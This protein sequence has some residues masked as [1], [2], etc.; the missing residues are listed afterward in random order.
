M[1]NTIQDQNTGDKE[2]NVSFLDF[3]NRTK[4]EEKDNQ[5]DIH[6]EGC[7]SCGS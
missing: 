2:D 4:F 3:K 6:D 5:C 1:A 7:I